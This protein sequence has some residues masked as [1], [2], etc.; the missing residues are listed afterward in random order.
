[1]LRH[2]KEKHGRQI[3]TK[4][5]ELKN[6][7]SFNEWKR[8]IEDETKSKYVKYNCYKSQKQA[9]RVF[10][11][12][13]SGCFQS[14]SRGLRHLRLAGSEKINGYCPAEIKLTILNANK[15]CIVNF[16]EQHVGHG[17]ELQF[18]KLQE[19]REF[20]KYMD[21]GVLEVLGD[22]DE[23]ACSGNMLAECSNLSPEERQL[24]DT[25]VINTWL[26]DN[27]DSVLF[28]KDD[29][30]KEKNS[31]NLHLGFGDDFVLVIMNEFQIDMFKQYGSDIVAVNRMDISCGYGLELTIVM[32][33]DNFHQGIPCCFLLSNRN[34]Q[35]VYEIMFSKM[36]EQVGKVRPKVFMSHVTDVFM[37]A[38]NNVMP[39]PERRL[40]CSW[41]VLRLWEKNLSKVRNVDVRK[42]LRQFLYSLRMELNPMRFHELLQEFLRN[43]NDELI[44]FKEYFKEYFLENVESWA[45]CY[46]K[47][48]G[49]NTN[50]VTERFLRA[51]KQIYL[52]NKSEY[53]FEEG[54]DA[55]SLLLKNL[56]FEKVVREVKG[57]LVSKLKHLRERHKECTNLTDEQVNLIQCIGENEWYVPSF[58]IDVDEMYHVERVVKSCDCK[59]RCYPCKSCLHEYRCSCLD[60][61]IQC[62]MC[63]HIHLVCILKNKQ[64]KNDDLIEEMVVNEIDSLI[65]PSFIASINED[66]KT[67]DVIDEYD[68]KKELEDV[69]LSHI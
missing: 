37:K 31:E 60:N 46:R 8:R 41:H 54:L 18:L 32:V 29:V 55:L 23:Y 22:V 1:M 51:F 5:I 17:Q 34:D 9:V 39:P 64:Q 45:Y 13:R 69:W 57:K 62:N 59:L 10:I 24:S 47:Y 44:E 66:Y 68:V 3:E 36:S 20:K 42:K 40:L 21:D 4:T 11:C 19:P 67:V 15:K 28:F 49:I 61:C 50:Y 25:I 53:T 33:L 35:K 7:Q 14:R 38:W 30:I 43:P 26:N 58:G 48:A 63:T 16:T 27:H 52:N 65:E 2:F 56:P 6:E 12:H